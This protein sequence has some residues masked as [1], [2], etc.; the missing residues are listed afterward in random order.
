MRIVSLMLVLSLMFSCE[1]RYEDNERL[2]FN[3]KI[4]GVNNAPLS[5]ISTELYATNFS[6]NDF[7]LDPLLVSRFFDD[8]DLIGYGFS[9]SDGAYSITSISPR[10]HVEIVAVVNGSTAPNYQED[11]ITAY[12]LYLN[13]K[14]NDKLSFRVPNT[15]LAHRILFEIN[16]QRTTNRTD[17]LEYFI[18]YPKLHK[19]Q[20][21]PPNT[22]MPNQA[23]NIGFVQVLPEVLQQKDT[24]AIA[25][26]DTLFFNYTI[27]N[28]TVIA[29]GAEELII[30]ATNN[31]YT[32]EF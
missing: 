4:L 17:T 15:V 6:V 14:A 20:R 9:E 23:N 27:K 25:E 16:I 29:A 10:N 1:L 19:I 32:F 12:Y 3:G 8:I 18:S 13:N 2:V 24:I 7:E 5:N 11:R 22:Q 21:F 28:D 31:A 26:G 30:S